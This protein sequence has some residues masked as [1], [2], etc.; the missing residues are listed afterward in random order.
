MGLARLIYVSRATSLYSREELAELVRRSSVSNA[1]RD[2]SGALIY[3]DGYF[4]QLLEG[5]D[6]GLVALLA[7]IASDSRHYDVQQLSLRPILSRSFQGWGMSFLHEENTLHADRVR[8][9]KIIGRLES[10]PCLEELGESAS[11]L[12]DE[13]KS[14]IDRESGAA[15]VRR[16]A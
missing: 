1:R 12:L 10:A 14:S 3:S 4:L 7:R 2:I 16:A 13:L 11:V 5:A 15:G 9:A 6:S 8:I